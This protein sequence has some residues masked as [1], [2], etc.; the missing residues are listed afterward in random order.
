MIYRQPL[1]TFGSPASGFPHS[2]HAILLRLSFLEVVVSS[3]NM[4]Y[5]GS[6]TGTQFCF[7]SR[8]LSSRIISVGAMDMLNFFAS[9]RTELVLISASVFEAKRESQMT[10]NIRTGAITSCLL[11]TSRFKS[12]SSLLNGRFRIAF[13]QIIIHWTYTLCSAN[14]STNRFRTWHAHHVR[15]LIIH[16]MNIKFLEDTLFIS[17]VVCIPD[18]T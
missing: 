11:P 14:T 10:Y 13:S 7:G 16:L 6:C 2:A 3:Q 12:S 1:Q 17:V 9:G 18:G 5:S 4:P 15:H 8:Y